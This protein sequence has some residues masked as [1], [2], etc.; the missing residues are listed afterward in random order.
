LV[1][2]TGV[3]V[4]RAAFVARCE[5]ARE[6]GQSN[7]DAPGICGL[8]ASPGH[9]HARLLITD[10]RARDMLAAQLP[11]AEA[12]MITVF[13]AAPRC[14]ALVADQTTWTSDESTAMICRDL[15]DVPAPALPAGLTLRPV[16]RSAGERPDGVPLEDA[17]AAVLRA[18]PAMDDPAETFAAYL[19]SLPSSVRLL[20]AV[21][22]EGVVR[23]TSGSSTFGAEARVFFVNTD[24][25]WRRR[26]VGQAMTAGALLAARR[27]GAR[28]ACLDAS[29]AGRSIYSRLGFETVS[30]TVRFFGRERDQVL[31]DERG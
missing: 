29:D 19:R 8:L 23:A 14:R 18:N 25:D 20:C 11:A 12:G 3:D 1:G 21:D 7:V 27:S 13:A 2:V 10:D 28:R 15:R 9:M 5:A 22:R 30:Q 4:Y 24:P 31:T 17:V 26:G 16:R 6:P